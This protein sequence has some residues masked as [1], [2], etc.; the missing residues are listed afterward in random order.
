MAFKQPRVPEYKEHEGA[1]K[2]IRELALFLKDFCTECWK[3]VMRT[4]QELSDLEK[5]VNMPEE[6]PPQ[7]M[8]MYAFHIDE[9]GH[10]I[11]TYDSTDPPPL[12]IDERGHLIYTIG[13]SDGTDD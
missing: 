4:Q 12:S 11:C 13:G 8:G 9:S 5:I 1:G 2:Y 3:M 6:E 7:A 10:L